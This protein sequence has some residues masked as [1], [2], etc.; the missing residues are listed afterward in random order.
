MTTVLMPDQHYALGGRVRIEKIGG[1][2]RETVWEDGSNGGFRMLARRALA[3]GHTVIVLSNASYDYMRL[4]D[5]GTQL[6]DRSY[7]RHGDVVN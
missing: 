1:A 6:L 5:L 7:M 2:D 3:D 4:G